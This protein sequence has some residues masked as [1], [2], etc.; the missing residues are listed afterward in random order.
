MHLS[1]KLQLQST[2][3]PLADRRSKQEP[4]DEFPTCLNRYA[5][6]GINQSDH[7]V[8]K[9]IKLDGNRNRKMTAS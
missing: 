2:A 5:A 8:R 3:A 7:E 9:T 1:R 4:A 6:K